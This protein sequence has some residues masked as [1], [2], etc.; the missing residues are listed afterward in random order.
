MKLTVNFASQGRLLEGT[1]YLPDTTDEVMAGCLFEG[2]MTG[3]T[4]QVVDYLAR[5]V[6]HQGFVTLIMDHNYFGDDETAPQPWESP[7][8]R[9]QDILAALHFLEDYGEV[10]KNRIFGVG[11]S[12]GGEFLAEAS[13]RTDILKGLIFVESPTDDT[14]N[15]IARLDIPSIVVDEAHLETAVDEIVLW[16]RTLFSSHREEHGPDINWNLTD[17]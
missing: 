1:L 12:V 3:A 10:D 9:L 15:R 13:R 8:K 6:S 7:F 17:K 16:A 11:V 4:A 2:A 14:R 5:E